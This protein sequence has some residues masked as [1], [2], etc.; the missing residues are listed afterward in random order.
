MSSEIWR[1]FRDFSRLMKKVITMV[2][3]D[4]VIRRAEDCMGLMADGYGVPVILTEVCKSFFSV[5]ISSEMTYRCILE[6][7]ILKDF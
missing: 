4:I 7:T 5:L 1:N 6:K 2:G 3:D